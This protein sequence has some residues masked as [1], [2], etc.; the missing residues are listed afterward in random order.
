MKR[1]SLLVAIML[2]VMTALPALA[3][4]EAPEV[5]A[6]SET[7]MDPT[8]EYV[9][10]AAMAGG[11]EGRVV[12]AAKHTAGHWVLLAWP[13]S[14]A[15]EP[16]VSPLAMDQDIAA[17]DIAPDGAL[18]V[19]L[20]SEATMPSSRDEGGIGDM[21]AQYAWLEADGTLAQ[22]LTL[23][24]M[25]V[26]ATALHDK[27]MA[28]NSYQD[29][30][31]IYDADGNAVK[32]LDGYSPVAMAATAE[33]L[34]IAQSTGIVQ[35]SLDSYQETATIP[36]AMPE[37]NSGYGFAANIPM[38]IGDDG[39]LY[40][41]EDSGMVC[42]NPVTL[43]NRLLLDATGKLLG[44]PTYST[45]GF[46]VR[47]DGEVLVTLSSG[48]QS[49]MGMGSRSGFGAATATEDAQTLLV[50][51]LPIDAASIA[52]RPA[53]IVSSLKSSEKLRKAVSDF[54]LAHPEIEVV[55]QIQVAEDDETPITDHIRTL[56]T[57]LLAGKGG[58]VLIL[59]DLPMT[60]YI[61]KGILVDLSALMPTLGILPNIV[62]GST[63]TDG[64]IYALPAQ[65]TFQ[66][67]FAGSE[68]TLAVTSLED[69]A[70]LPYADGQAPMAARTP[71]EW[72]RLF[73]PS[74]EQ[75]FKDASGQIHFNT[76]E[77]AAFLEALYMLYEAQ[78]ELPEVSST[79]AYGGSRAGMNLAEM[80]AIYNGSVAFY[81]VEVA[82]LM[83][84][85]NA[86]S[87]AGGTDG[88]A[89]TL[90]TM[91]GETKAYTPSILVGI[92][93]RSSQQALAQ[94]FI[95]TMF[96]MEVQQMDQLQGLSVTISMLDELFSQAIE[97]SQSVGDGTF[98]MGG[99]TM[100]V[101]QPDDAAWKNLRT[102]CESVSTPAILDE[103]LMAFI[104]SE[105]EDF[106]A[107][108]VSAATAAESLEQR[109]WF[110]LNE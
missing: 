110:Y 72:L 33:Y 48:A 95:Q 77:F 57:D 109:A 82:S 42:I 36:Y 87:L 17:I 32:Y 88:D 71:E 1:I 51:Y 37:A 105:T 50:S 90:P 97:W 22:T 84:L 78:E 28:V 86:Y 107:G 43:E 104:V 27:M 58:D 60:S 39:M 106:F 70:A 44:D 67:L 9:R 101:T 100:E 30:L 85:S 2:L 69:L 3:A 45:T 4:E 83:H 61:T 6:Y 52:E 62:Q 96:S 66:T 16:T 54:Q 89:I 38:S 23:S 98:A 68:L 63:H 40:L 31:I 46:T 65:Y 75:S 11:A 74:N 18:L 81:P 76:P 79:M 59:D 12:I 20:A 47:S 94:E 13:A 24:G 29:G 49:G 99:V 103:T 55:L 10:F 7:L 15:D 19:R 56:N 8:A 102:L 25:I 35:L 73:Y 108:R 5:G 64:K 93:A 34:F 80:I 92:N 21:T 41:L 53:F 26:S 91:D 14:L